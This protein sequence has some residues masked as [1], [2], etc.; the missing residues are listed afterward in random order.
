MR[1]IEWYSEKTEENYFNEFSTSIKLGRTYHFSENDKKGYVIYSA[2]FTEK[3]QIVAIGKFGTTEIFIKD[4][5][6]F[7]SKKLNLY[8]NKNEEGNFEKIINTNSR[9]YRN[10]SVRAKEKSIFTYK[11]KNDLTIEYYEIYTDI[12]AMLKANIINDKWY[13]N[14]FLND[15]KGILE[16]NDNSLKDDFIICAFFS[17]AEYLINSRKD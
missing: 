6:T 7:F 11:R 3:G 9:I 17:L 1:V 16:V 15:I 5:S 8:L 13:K 10:Y 4:E 2:D 12:L 14:V